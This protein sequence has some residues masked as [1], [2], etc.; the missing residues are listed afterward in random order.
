MST[1]YLDTC[2]IIDFIQG[3]VEDGRKIASAIAGKALVSSELARM[4]SRIHAL[5]QQDQR[6]LERFNMFFEISKMVPLDHHVF[7]IA[8]QLRVQHRLKT[9]DALHLALAMAG[10]CQ[11][12]GT[13]DHRFAKAAGHHLKVI[14][15][16]D[17]TPSSG[18]DHA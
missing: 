16:R 14:S 2:L 5:R 4:E 17:K 12:F 9:P 3:S 11:E 15:L 18:M 8:T 13:D 7:E 10:N 6:A 1:I